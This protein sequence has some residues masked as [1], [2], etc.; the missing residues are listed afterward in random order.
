M[1]LLNTQPHKVK[2]E[3]KRRRFLIWSYI[4]DFVKLVVL[5]LVF[6]WLIHR[7]VF[8]PFVV[9]G[10]SMEP[11]FHDGDYLI[12]ER[13]SYYLHNPERGDA[14]ILAAPQ[15]QN[16]FLIKR[17]IGLPN[18]RIVIKRGHVYIF[19]QDHPQGI[20]LSEDYL[21]SGLTTPGQIDYSLKD[22]EYFLLGDNRSISLDSRSFGP[23]SREDIV[24]RPLWRP[25]PL[26]ALGPI[27]KLNYGF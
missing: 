14:V 19:N 23:V 15:E 7:F 3:D 24:G 1:P 8:Q 13:V 18:E 6:V 5:A 10:P 9:F 12:I 27:K 2:Q 17:V 20:R 25:L 21:P 22:D 26:K 16:G 4:F 11:N